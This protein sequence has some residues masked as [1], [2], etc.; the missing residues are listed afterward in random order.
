MK[1][2]R[3]P[4]SILLLGEYA[5]TTAD[6]LGL[7]VAVNPCARAAYTA[8]EAFSV[9]GI[10]PEGSTDKTKTW[11]LVDKSDGTLTIV[12]AVIELCQAF[13]APLPLPRFRFTLDTR[14]FRG[15]AGKAGLG[16]SASGTVAL[17]AAILDAAD[18][19]PAR[20]RAA[21]P[22]LAVDAHRR[23]Q[24]GKGS[25]YDVLTAWYGGIGVFRGGPIPGWTPVSLP[26]I[27]H[28]HLVYGDESVSTP[29]AIGAFE[30]WATRH[31]NEAHEFHERSNAVVL[32]VAKTQN[33]LEPNTEILEL[34]REASLRGAILGDTIGRPVLVTPARSIARCIEKARSSVLK[35]LGAGGELGIVIPA[36]TE[37]SRR[38]VECGVERVSC[39]DT[40]AIGFFHE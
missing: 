13:L 30:T 11:R 18:V 5:I 27:S 20:I 19:P 17:A 36:D 6:G 33:E 24:Q 8:D 29:G 4:G 7:A 21:M 37:C 25:G 31:P 35:A 15:R 10:W 28:T 14:S 16:S 9:T 38:L 2:I 32:R 39:S 40:G 34:F 1:E 22:Q 23:A 26:W 3:A 12:E